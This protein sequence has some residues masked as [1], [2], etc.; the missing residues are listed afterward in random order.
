MPEQGNVV[1]FKATEQA[2]QLIEELVGAYADFLRQVTQ[3]YFGNVEQNLDQLPPAKQ[4]LNAAPDVQ[5][6]ALTI[7]LQNLSANRKPGNPQYQLTATDIDILR[8]MAIK[9]YKKSLPLTQAHLTTLATTAG[10][11]VNTGYEL[12]AGGVVSILEKFLKEGNV[13]NE[14]T[15]ALKHFAQALS[16]P[17]DSYSYTSD[18]DSKKMVQRIENLLGRNSG[19]PIQIAIEPGEAWSDEALRDLASMDAQARDNW[20]RL[21]EFFA[22]GASGTKPTNKWLKQSA[23]LIKGVSDTE[24]VR[25]AG[26]WLALMPLKGSRSSIN[27]NIQWEPDPADVICSQNA[28]VLKGLAWSCVNY[29]NPDLISALGDAAEASFKKV[30]NLGPRCPKLGNACIHTLSEMNTKEAIAQLSRVQARAKHASSK[31]QIEKA[32]GNAAEQA[33]MSV[34]D[35]QDLG[36]PDFG[37]TEVGTLTKAFG[38][39]SATL[40]LHHEG[41]STTWRSSD[42]KEQEAIPAAVKKEHPEELKAL[43]KLQSELE[44]LLPTVSSRIERSYIDQ[45]HWSFLSWKERYLNHPV[46]G[47][48]SRKLV[49][50]FNGQAAIWLDGKLVNLSGEEVLPEQDCIVELW[51]PIGA[52]PQTV[53]AWRK[54]LRGHEIVQPFKQCHREI[55]VLTD[56]ERETETHSNRFAGHLVRQ[57]Q[58]QHVCMSR[59]WQYKLMGVF[60]F[61]SLPTLQL[62]KWDMTVEFC[63]ET[64]DGRDD[65]TANGIFRYVATDKVQF[66]RKSSKPVELPPQMEAMR[67]LLTQLP[68]HMRSGKLK[69][70]VNGGEWVSYEAVPLTEILPVVFSEVMRDVDLF[71]S[72]CSIGA[73]PNA[74]AYGEHWHIAAFGELTQSA[75]T[76]REILAEIIPALK[77]AS[78]CKIEGRFLH[79]QGELREYKIHLGSGNI[80]MEPNDEYLCIVASRGHLE[81]KQ[82]YYLPFEGDQLLSVIL[83]KAFMLAEDTKITDQSILNQIKRNM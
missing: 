54:W 32:I 55:Y 66:S 71:V 37:M 15:E 48:I 13:S 5:A 20:A 17:K 70:Y 18:A 50:T 36:L 57:H 22:R 11:L 2:K 30:K 67:Q 6:E 29:N 83:S 3:T 41:A 69:K 42:G 4:L 1:T 81:P 35:L 38:N 24:F 28:D 10:D 33:G 26:K 9:L 60:D 78:R 51:H 79:V 52:E 76:R 40:T 59:G 77:I 74:G 68:S 8:P 45:R 7:A 64:G 82:K 62:P 25:Y 80:M 34:D 31:T 49:W 14:L 19:A 61:Q 73:D 39:W 44:K 75:E 63:I 23:E 43:K 58:L 21:I 12:P 53:L 65:D 27:L 16:K 72:V 46:S 56:A 47:V